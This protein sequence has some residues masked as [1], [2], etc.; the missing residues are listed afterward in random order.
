[1][2]SRKRAPLCPRL[3]FVPTTIKLKRN[4]P[5]RLFF[6]K[7]TNDQSKGARTN[8]LVFNN[9]SLLYSTGAP[10]GQSSSARLSCSPS[11]LVGKINHWARRERERKRDAATLATIASREALDAPIGQ[12]KRAPLGAP[13]TLWPL[14]TDSPA[15]LADIG[16]DQPR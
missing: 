15:S 7:Q 5:V 13:S 8:Q 11:H 14:C 3:Q 4:S 16:L 9:L 1:M 6:L 2:P 12:H 10:T